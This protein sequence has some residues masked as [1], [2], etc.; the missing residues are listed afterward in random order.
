M[1]YQEYEDIAKN[2]GHVP[3]QAQQ[4]YTELAKLLEL[5]DI[6]KPKKI[7]ELGVYH[8]GTVMAWTHVATP[9]AL[10]IGVDL[11]GGEFGGGFDPEQAMRI[12]ALAKENQKIELLPLNTHLQS[13][14]DLIAQ[15]GEFDFIFIDAD[16]TYE[17]VKQDFELYSK[18]LRKDGLI[19]FHDI[20][21]HIHHPGVEVQKFW[22]ELKANYPKERV[23][24]FTDPDFPS[25]HNPWGGLGVI[26]I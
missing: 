10:I 4:K 14:F 8:G 17:G 3:F 2:T 11:P 7:L 18:L 9:D 20:V 19:A 25:D 13:T 1:T 24:E 26:Q 22:I 15:Y 5:V 16:H 12:K 23:W 21:E 6:L